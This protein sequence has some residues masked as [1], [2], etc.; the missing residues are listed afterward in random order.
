MTA[1]MT[2]RAAV[3][4]LCQDRGASD[5]DLS[6][7][8]ATLHCPLQQPLAATHFHRRKE[9][10]FGKIRDVLVGAAHADEF[11]DLIVV[12]RELR[13]RDRPIIAVAI[14]ACSFEFVV[15][16]P[17]ALTAPSDRA[18]T[19]VPAANPIKRFLVRGR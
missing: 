6:I 4:F 5:G 1:V 11:L 16:Q 18:A 9:L 13:V 19:H 15:R 12:W 10:A 3:M 7:F 17:I 14:T 2:G 8:P